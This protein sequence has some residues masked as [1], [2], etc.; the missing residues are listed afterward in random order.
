MPTKVLA[1]RFNTL[2]DRIENIL[3]PAEETN[4]AAANNGYS[5]GYGQALG[6]LVDQSSSNDLID[7]LAYKQ[8]YINVLKIRFHQVGTSAFTADPFVVG[9]FATNAASTDKILEA[10]IQGIETLATNMEN[11]RLTVHPSQASV[12]SMGS[13]T[14]AT[15]WNGTLSHIFQITFT[16]AQ[17]RRQFFNA[18]GK[19]RFSTNMNYTGSQAK[20]LD[21]K[22]MLAQVGTV[23]FAYSSTTN[24]T[25]VGQSYGGI[26]HDYMFSYY[27][28]AYYNSGGGV[29]NPN[30]YT[31]YAMEMND[32]VLQF[33]VEFSDPSYGVPDETVLG[34]VTSDIEAVVPDGTAS[35]DG[36]MQTTVSVPSPTYTLVS[37]L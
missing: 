25:G 29:Y 37:N 16:D 5:Y 10:Y 18:G 33:K 30:R 11:D 26:G 8:L 2:K 19:I 35:I 20:S 28:T 17:A 1:S 6:P 12:Q 23:D 13:S 15:S 32:S 24:S 31:V 21:W 3:G 22:N 4:R 36:T 14:S 27:Q 7:A 9:D 34:A